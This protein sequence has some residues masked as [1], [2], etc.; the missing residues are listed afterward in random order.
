M[1]NIENTVE[2]INQMASKS[3]EMPKCLNFSFE[4][5][6]G[7]RGKA[8]IRVD[9]A[10]VKSGLR[11]VD[12]WLI[13]FLNT[14][15]K[16]HPQTPITDICVRLLHTPNSAELESFCRRLSYLAINNDWKATIL[17]DGKTEDYC[18]VYPTIDALLERPAD[19]VVREEC[20]E[21][22]DNPDSAGK[23]EKQLQTWLA[24]E[25]RLDNERLALLGPDFIFGKSHK[26]KVIREFPTGSFRGSKSSNNRILPTYWVDLVTLNKAR[27]LAIIELKINDGKLDVLAQALDYALFFSCYRKR[28]SAHLSKDLDCPVAASIKIACYVA[29]NCFHQKFPEV[30]EF[31]APRSDRWPFILKQ[32]VFGM[33]STLPLKNAS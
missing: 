32:C 31:Y 8:T 7:D 21:R 17:V 11:S 20:D 9:Q 19:E 6:G 5:T 30:S 27:Q 10:G 14:L 26:S 33:L 28:L 18:Q 13:V 15:R 4:N 3:N 23:I 1:T 22:H 24:G 29:S 25:R 16:E 12:P 2:R